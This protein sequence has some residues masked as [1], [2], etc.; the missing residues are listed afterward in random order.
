MVLFFI[1]EV[2]TMNRKNFV[3]YRRIVGKDLLLV[4]DAISNDAYLSRE[5]WFDYLFKSYL[6]GFRSQNIKKY[7]AFY[8]KVCCIAEIYSE[9]FTYMV[10]IGVDGF[11]NCSYLS[12][13]KR[14][15]SRMNKLI[16]RKNRVLIEG[17]DKDGVFYIRVSK[18]KIRYEVFSVSGKDEAIEKIKYLVGY[19]MDRV[20]G[21]SANA[22]FYTFLKGFLSAE[23]KKVVMNITP[24]PY[25]NDSS[26]CTLSDYIGVSDDSVYGDFIPTRGKIL[27]IS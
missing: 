17:Y 4:D 13:L 19:C 18:N 2:T 5:E 8:K 12:Y 16:T 6:I 24:T 20:E 3:S 22:D 23:Y 10:D 1:T 14:I 7:R 25:M 15:V 9:A 27:S 11:K 26:R 21:L